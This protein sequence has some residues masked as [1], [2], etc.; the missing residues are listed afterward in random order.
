MKTLLFKPF[1]KYSEQKLLITGILGAIIGTLLTYFLKCKFIGVLKMTFVNEISISKSSLDSVIIVS[2]LTLFLF[3]AAKYIYKKTRL[4]DIIVT[5]LVAYIPLYI[6]P[7]F[8][9]NDTI[10]IA[11]E[12]ILKYSSPELASQIP[13]E[14]ITPLA[15]FGLFTLLILIWFIVLLYNGFKT[16][17]NAKG[18]KAMVIF[19][20]ALLLADVLSRI[21]IQNIN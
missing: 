21:I 16:A 5:T 2:C 20:I 12:N 6:L 9:I 7:I 4:I 10:K 19:G 17:S 8:N 1:E 11:T 13:L 15:L 3:L 14:S 18:T